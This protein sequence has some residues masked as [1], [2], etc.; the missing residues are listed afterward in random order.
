M[1]RVKRGTVRAAKRK[2]MLKLA[3]G[4]TRRSTMRLS[5][6]AA[7]SVTSASC[8]WCA[9]TPPRVSTASPTGA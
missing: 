7:R 3:K 2:K 8:G 9:S 1:P 4:S 6:V 5:V